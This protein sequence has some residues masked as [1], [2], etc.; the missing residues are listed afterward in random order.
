MLF[1]EK[2]VAKKFDEK[3]TKG[4]ANLTL[5]LRKLL[6]WQVYKSLNREA[7]GWE[8]P[9][10]PFPQAVDIFEVGNWVYSGTS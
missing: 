10:E 5:K 1:V 8:P 2:T 4:K 9:S 6:R 7:R 3:R